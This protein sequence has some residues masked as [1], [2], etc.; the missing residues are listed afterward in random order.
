MSGLSVIFT[1][2]TS[3]IAYT[4]SE[5]AQ[6]IGTL[7]VVLTLTLKVFQLFLTFIHT[8]TSFAL[9]SWSSQRIFCIK[10]YF[11]NKKVIGSYTPIIQSFCFFLY[12]HQLATKLVFERNF[13]SRY[14]LNIEEFDYTSITQIYG[15][16]YT[17]S[18][19]RY[20]YI[21]IPASMFM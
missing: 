6:V 11:S 13:K 2:S 14:T 15:A 9:R 5:D 3:N 4:S 16:H 20:Y 17:A 12:I 21:W 7:R 19:N 18:S 1:S 8:S 10:G